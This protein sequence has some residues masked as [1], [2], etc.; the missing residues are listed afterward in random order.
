M[1]L[2]SASLYQ[3]VGRSPPEKNLTFVFSEFLK[4]FKIFLERFVTK[5]CCKMVQ[6]V[7]QRLPVRF[8][9]ITELKRV[10][11]FLPNFR[12]P[13]KIWQEST[14]VQKNSSY[15]SVANC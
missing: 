14:F 5:K 9:L 12:S 6:K 3:A 10:V 1:F 2:V 15:A 7:L 13:S 8:S 11:E 4:K